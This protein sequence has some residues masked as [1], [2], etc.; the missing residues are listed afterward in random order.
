MLNCRRRRM[1]A[2]VVA[3]AMRATRLESAVVALIYRWYN[4]L[5]ISLF[6]RH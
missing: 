6:V 1:P 2:N 4:R 3:D 5:D